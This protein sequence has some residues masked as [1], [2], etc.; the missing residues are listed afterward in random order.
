MFSFSS[1]PHLQHSYSSCSSL[2]A[3]IA[4]AFSAS[5]LSASRS[6]A[7]TMRSQS[8]LQ[9]HSPATSAAPAQCS[10]KVT[11]D[12]GGWSPWTV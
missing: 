3:A 2:F 11:L 4:A 10:L 5:L 1:P 12:N 9:Q 6:S 8:R 7:D